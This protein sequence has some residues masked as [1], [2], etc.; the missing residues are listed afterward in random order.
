MQELAQ[1]GTMGAVL[2][3]QLPNLAA[4]PLARKCH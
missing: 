1:N 2:Q 3:Y 4:L